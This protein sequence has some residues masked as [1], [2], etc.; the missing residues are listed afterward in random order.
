V[1]DVVGVD[2]EQ[3]VEDLLR[4]LLADFIFSFFFFFFFK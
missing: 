4:T 2:V 3:R 1:R